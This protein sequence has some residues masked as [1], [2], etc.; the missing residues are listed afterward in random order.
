M[1]QAL[2]LVMFGAPGSGKGTQAEILSERL[3]VPAISTGEML[4]EAVATG[5]DL[6]KRV[7]SIMASGALVDDST[8]ADVVRE[9]LAQTD[10]GKGFILDGYPRTIAQADSLEQILNEQG[11]GL[12]AVA[13][14][15]VPEEQL[16]QRLLA[17]QRADDSEKV[18]RDR[19]RVYHE[20]TEPL[21]DYYDGRSLLR[22]VDGDR[23]IDAVAL[24]LLEALGLAA[25]DSESSGVEQ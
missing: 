18:I 1:G 19:Q 24:A 23:S 14:I 16:V 25:L 4:R 22:R 17:R 8:M 5:S 11:S 3:G 21:I 10:A 20:S 12:D 7:E 15:T 13:F 9:R 6:G 2:R